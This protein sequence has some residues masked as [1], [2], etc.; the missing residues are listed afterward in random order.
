MKK[1]TLSVWV[2]L[3]FLLTAESC[4]KSPGYGGLAQITGKVYVYDYN[5]NNIL[6]AEGYTADVNVYISADDQPGQLDDVGTD[7]NGAFRFD[8]LRKGKY[9]VWVFE[10]CDTCTE[11]KRVV[12][13]LV[14]IEK[15]N[16]KIELSDFKIK[17]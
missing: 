8:G 9:T 4:K 10:D 17:I 15:N 6:E 7:I 16:A 2:L 14:T 1:I 3:V 11:N 12:K 13:Q 5:T